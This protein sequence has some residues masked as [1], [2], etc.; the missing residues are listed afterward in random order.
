[1]PLFPVGLH[2]LQLVPLV[3]EIINRRLQRKISNNE[4]IINDIIIFQNLCQQWINLMTLFI[5]WMRN[6]QS[7][8]KKTNPHTLIRLLAGYRYVATID[9]YIDFI[10][11]YALS[12]DITV[13]IP[14]GH[15][16]IIMTCG[17]I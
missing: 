13:T 8:K 4:N 12:C 3:L 7:S 11:E 9:T 10:S 15:L 16:I 17:G 14:V 6:R 2:F 5:H 1:M